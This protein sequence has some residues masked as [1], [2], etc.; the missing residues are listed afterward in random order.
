MVLLVCQGWKEEVIEEIRS[1]VPWPLM[2]SFHPWSTIF[3]TWCLVVRGRYIVC[4]V[5]RGVRNHIEEEKKKGKGFVR[6]LEVKNLSVD[7][8]QAV[9]VPRTKEKMGR[10]FRGG[11][12]KGQGEGEKRVQLRREPEKIDMSL[13]RVAGK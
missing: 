11:E 9:R 7:R 13:I 2:T 1:F 10:V 3:I 8:A 5:E 4:C 6:S 12:R